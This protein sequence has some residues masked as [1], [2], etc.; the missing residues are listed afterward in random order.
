MPVGCAATQ[1]KLNRLE[2]RANKPHK[3]QQWEVQM[4]ALEEEQPD[5][6]VYA[7]ELAGK[8]HCRKG[9]VGP[10]AYQLDHQQEMCPGGKGLH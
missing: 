5:A 4:L 8:Q 1:H 2:K 10:C 3:V 9:V 7:G 6:T